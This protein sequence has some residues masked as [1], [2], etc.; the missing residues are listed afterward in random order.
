MEKEPHHPLTNPVDEP[1]PTK[2]P[3]LYEPDD[4]P[5]KGEDPPGEIEPPDPHPKRDVPDT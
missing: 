4:D 2:W 3:D 5:E 1:D